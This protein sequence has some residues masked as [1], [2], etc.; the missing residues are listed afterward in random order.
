MRIRC[1]P[2]RRSVTARTFEKVSRSSRRVPGRC[3]TTST[4]GPPLRSRS[5]RRKSAPSSLVKISNRSM[6]SLPRWWSTAYS[7]PGRRRSTSTGG[8]VGSAGS[9]S[10]HSDEDFEPRC[11]TMARRSR[12][13]PSDSENRASSSWK[14]KTSSLADD[15]SSWR[16][17][18]CGRMVSSTL[19]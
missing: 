1:A 5:T 17:T 8:A 6:P 10:Q 18:W 12:L 7:W 15:E 3:G 13:V 2:L 11:T 4:V 9:I 19:V 16:Q 14:T